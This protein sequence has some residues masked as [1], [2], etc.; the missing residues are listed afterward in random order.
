M[1]RFRS[2][3]AAPPACRW[4][5][6][7]RR[8]AS[9]AGRDPRAG[10]D[11]RYLRGRQSRKP[12]EAGIHGAIQNEF[13]RGAGRHAPSALERERLHAYAAGQRGAAFCEPV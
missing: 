11:H 9:A 8:P 5:G 1:P 7:R 6:C 12:A 3:S 13:Q 2:S 4:S 10:G